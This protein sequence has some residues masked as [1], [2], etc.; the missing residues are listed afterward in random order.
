DVAQPRHRRQ[1]RAEGLQPPRAS[2]KVE[3][4]PGAASHD[5]QPAPG[6]AGGNEVATDVEPHDPDL[7]PRDESDD[8]GDEVAPAAEDEVAAVPAHNVRPAPLDAVG[9]AAGRAGR[10]PSRAAAAGWQAE[11]PDAPVSAQL[12]V[13]GVQHGK[14]LEVTPPRFPQAPAAAAEGRE[15]TG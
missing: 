14:L 1:D 2:V 10:G 7:P 9:V 6:V 4:G 8:A 12:A 5:P 13:A 11:S 15:H 3:A